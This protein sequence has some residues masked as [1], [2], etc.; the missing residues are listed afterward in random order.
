[1]SQELYQKLYD[2]K[3]LFYGVAGRN[4]CPGV[5]LMPLYVPEGQDV[6]DDVIKGAL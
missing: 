6:D 2:D 1:M 3:E 4:R 5:R